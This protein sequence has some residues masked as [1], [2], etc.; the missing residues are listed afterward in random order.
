MRQALNGAGLGLALGLFIAVIITALAQGG[1]LEAAY[2]RN[3]LCVLLGAGMGS[4]TGALIG[5]V[6]AIVEAMQRQ[7]QR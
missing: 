6:G 2:L 4:L 1:A 7:S 3:V 5:G